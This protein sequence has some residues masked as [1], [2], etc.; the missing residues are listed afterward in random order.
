MV[1]KKSIIENKYEGI[2]YYELRELTL[3]AKSKGLAVVVWSYPRGGALAKADETAIDVV[4][5]AAH[6]AAQMGANIIKIKPPDNHI[7]DQEAKK[8]MKQM[9]NF[10][11]ILYSKFKSEILKI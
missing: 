3:E 4:A 1:I 5:Y 10:S 7:F 2:K 8:N 9:N 6:I 11:T